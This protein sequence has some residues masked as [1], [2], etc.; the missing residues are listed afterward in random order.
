MAEKRV[1]LALCQGRHEM[2]SCVEGAIFSQEVNPLD[3]QG[4][5]KQALDKLQSLD[6]NELNLFVTGLTVALV[7][8]LNAAKA[9][10]IKVVLYHFNKNTGD[11]YPQEVL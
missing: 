3:C 8:T 10:K 6:C 7:A 1:S 4:L 2:P 9:L 11:Y 5:E